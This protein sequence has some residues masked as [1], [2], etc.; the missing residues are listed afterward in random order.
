MR[1]G[2]ALLLLIALC[3]PSSRL[4][5]E[6]PVDSTK[7]PVTQVPAKYLGEVDTKVQSIDQ[8]LTSQTTRYLNKLSG[9]E[10]RILKK[11][12]KAD[13]S[14]T[15]KLPSANYQQLEAQM[16][17][18]VIGAGGSGV[19]YVPSL[20]TLQTTLKFL[21]SQQGTGSPTGLSA[22]P[23]GSSA[24]LTQTSAQ[25]QQLQ[26]NLNTSALVQ[27]YITQRKQELAQLLSQY[28]HLPPGV[29]QAFTQFKATG[30]YYSQQ[31]Q[32]YKAML[33]NPQ[34]M[35]QTAIAVLSK[36]PA[37]QQYLTKYSVLAS[38]F[39]L[40]AGYGNSTAL[41]GLQTQSQIQSLVQQ[42][43]ATSGGSAGAVQQQLQGAQTQIT[44]IQNSLAKY[45]AGGQNLDM[46]NF[47]PNSQKTKTLLKRLE[48]G[49]NVQ[50]AKSAYDF[51]ATGNLGLTIGYKIN[52]KSTIG[53][54]AS[55][56][57]GLGTGW[58]FIQFTNQGVGLRSYMD[59]KIKKTY[60]VTGGYELN[61][62]SQFASIEQ[63][64]N[65]S[66]WQPSA[67]IG[68]EKKYK[69]S[70]KLT[71]DMQLLFDALYRQEI[72]QGQAIKFRV[73]YNF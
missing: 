1:F 36:L 14:S 27:Q 7:V 11:L 10:A 5:A 19:N 25:V 52:D 18:P 50:F 58:N 66:A 54:G 3:I 35:E 42:A 16:Q 21:Q 23:S 48:Y 45:G 62:M 71:G 64:Q 38:L 37:Y 63:L 22:L 72:P 67:L 26:A 73:G 24:Q 8:S 39:Q 28:T 6:V 9:L 55:Y 46:P 29:T 17:H 2:P 60:Y 4:Y 61:Y 53:V 69:I 13:S 31:V 56:N 32:Q 49:M 15:A 12:H 34:K 33:N 68:L 20:D 51:P 70:S 44:N 30:Y 65:R 47:Q 41:Q 43:G 59:W 40:P 57:I